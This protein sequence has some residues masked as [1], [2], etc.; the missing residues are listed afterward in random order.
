M[1]HF[2]PSIHHLSACETLKILV[3][4]KQ[5]EHK[6]SFS[7]FPSLRE[8]ACLCTSSRKNSEDKTVFNSVYA[9]KKAYALKY[10]SQHFVKASWRQ[11]KG[12]VSLYFADQNKCSASWPYTYV[13]Q[14]HTKHLR[15]LTYPIADGGRTRTR[16]FLTQ[17]PKLLCS[18][19]HQWRDSLY[20][21]ILRE[22][23]HNGSQRGFWRAKDFSLLIACC[24][25]FWTHA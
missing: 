25:A 7:Y 13:L 8:N 9:R 21:C 22:W 18:W 16:L 19:L 12:K 24:A 6:S 5:K 1:R 23:D 17:A 11:S 15:K 2:L 20:I 14:Y 10:D 4:P 3:S